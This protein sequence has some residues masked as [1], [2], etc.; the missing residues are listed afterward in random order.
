MKLWLRLCVS[1]FSESDESD[2]ILSDS[3]EPPYVHEAEDGTQWSSIPPNSS[4][5]HARD[6]IRRPINKIVNANYHPFIHPDPFLRLKCCPCP[7]LWVGS[8]RL[9]WTRTLHA[10]LFS[11]SMPARPH[12]LTSVFTH[13]D[14]VFL[15]L[16]C[17]LV[18]GNWKFV[19]DLIQD[20]VAE[21]G[22]P[23]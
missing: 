12:L 3:E 6:I 1:K 15:S 14:H 20:W 8:N 9:R 18:L 2:D 10:S 16:P 22:G 13:W 4:R 11:G 21:S 19:I 17:L 7:S 5:T 23:T